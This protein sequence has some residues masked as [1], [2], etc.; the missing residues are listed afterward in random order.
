L[1]C[2]EKKG[3]FMPD[4]EASF[5]QAQKETDQTQTVDD[6]SEEDDVEGL[7]TEEDADAVEEGEKEKEP[8]ADKQEKKVE[9]QQ[10]NVSDL[11]GQIQSMQNHIKNLNIALSTERKKNKEETKTEDALTDEQLRQLFHEHKD[12]PDTI[13]NLMRYMVGEGSKKATKD[14]VSIEK[15]NILKSKQDS[16]IAE[17]FPDMLDESK[18]LKR[19]VEDHKKSW[20]LETHPLGDFLA[21][22]GVVVDQIPVIQK[23]AYEAGKNDAL[24]DKVETDRKKSVKE[25]KLLDGKKSTKKG[26]P[27]E[28]NENQM[29]VIKRLGLSKSGAATYAKILGKTK[30]KSVEA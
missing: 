29:D 4:E 17:R 7:E 24:K 15:I 14:A 30:S 2:K 22:A 18:P 26:S 1:P 13:Y 28:L 16:Y 12:D 21:I 8:A 25:D 20:N 10:P 27:V 9:K 23:Q 5:D 3:G 6:E 19:L 11:Q